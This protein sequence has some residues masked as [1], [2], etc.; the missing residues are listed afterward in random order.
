V[1]A[2]LGALISARGRFWLA[3]AI[4]GA[5]AFWCLGALALGG[6][7]LTAPRAARCAIP[8]AGIW[9]NLSDR[10]GVRFAAL[11]LLG[12]LGIIAGTSLVGVLTGPVLSVIA[13]FGW[14]IRGALGRVVRQWC[15]RQRRRRDRLLSQLDR[16]GGGVT[17]RLAWYPT[18]A[19]AVRPTRVGNAFAALDQR[20]RRR[21][22]L[23]LSTCW[24]LIEQTLPQPARDRLEAASR[25]VAG[26]I[27]NL[28][29]T[30][31]ALAWLPAF[32]ARLAVLIAVAC[33]VLA[34]L[35]W[36]AVSGAVEQY[37]A[38]IEATVAAHRRAMY[39]AVGWCP[40]TSTAQEPERGRA[41]TG[42]LNRLSDVG[43]VALEWP[44][45][46]AT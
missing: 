22:G 43:D 1:D 2:I 32:P 12:V 15:S 9:C 24:P 44:D 29:W 14:P 10:G 26:R 20:V 41:L 7:P 8:E 21:H 42:Y 13:G 35:L 31:A 23:D 45:D 40:P 25:R 39:V 6:I 17:A 28:L 11:V 19:A 27:Q 16:G 3:S 38:L 18:G 33:A 37:C 5:V 34:V 36:W 30:V 46:A 4:P